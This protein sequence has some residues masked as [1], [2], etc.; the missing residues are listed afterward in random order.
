VD[1]FTVRK[2][3]VLLCLLLL[4]RTRRHERDTVDFKIGRFAYVLK[5]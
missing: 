4:D 2:S 3:F 5:F 1:I